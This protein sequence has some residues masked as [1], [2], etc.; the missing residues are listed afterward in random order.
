MVREVLQA[1]DAQTRQAAS[2]QGRSGHRVS[3][4]RRWNRQSST[5]QRAVPHHALRCGGGAWSSLVRCTS[6]PTISVCCVVGITA[7]CGVTFG[8]MRERVLGHGM[9]LVSAPC[10][11]SR[12]SLTSFVI[13]LWMAGRFATCGH[14][15][16]DEVATKWAQLHAPDTSRTATHHMLV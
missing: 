16:A 12:W 13:T 10:P 6:P 1:S 14:G 15:T 3:A 7:S 9:W 4:T 8:V 5:R 2:G 11:H